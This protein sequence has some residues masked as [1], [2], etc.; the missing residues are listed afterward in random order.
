[1]KQ[2]IISVITLLLLDFMWIGLFMGKQYAN[3]IPKIQGNDISTRPGYGVL[4]YIL[5][6]IGLLV[7]VLPNIRKEYLIEDSLKYGL[8]FGIVL[9]GVYDFTAGAVLNNWDMKIAIYDILWGGIVFFL[10]SLIGGYFS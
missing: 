2:Q 5:M 4:S 8:L 1:M 7:F 3:M 9:Y 6:V 10:A